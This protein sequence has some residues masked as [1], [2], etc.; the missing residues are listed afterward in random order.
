LVLRATLSS[1]ADTNEKI[2]SVRIVITHHSVSFTN[3]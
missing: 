3:Q 2:H 1:S